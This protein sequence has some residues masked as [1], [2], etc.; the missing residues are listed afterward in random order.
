MSI[1]AVFMPSTSVGLGKS[2]VTLCT[3]FPTATLLETLR[4]VKADLDTATF[5]AASEEATA[6]VVEN[7]EKVQ[8]IVAVV[9][10]EAKARRLKGEERSIW[11]S[12][13]SK[14]TWC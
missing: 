4:G 3:F 7:W 13:K 14:A 6:A 8:A 1:P 10:K 11:G 2:S 9:A 5:E 12:G